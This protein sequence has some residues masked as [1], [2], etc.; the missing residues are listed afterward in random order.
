LT[1]QIRRRDGG[2]RAAP[3]R[4]Q[5]PQ[6][7]ELQVW[8]EFFEAFEA[9]RSE[10]VS[11]LLAEVSMSAEDYVVLIALSEGPGERLRSSQLAEAVTWERSRLSHHLGRMERRGWSAPTPAISATRDGSTTL[12]TLLMQIKSDSMYS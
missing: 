8:R 2:R 3:P 6:A 11:R 12:G 1:C 10:V 9:L 5:L 4:R 7:G